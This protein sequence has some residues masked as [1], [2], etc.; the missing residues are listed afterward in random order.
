MKRTTCTHVRHIAT[1]A[2]AL[3]WSLS[4]AMC[5]ANTLHHYIF[6][7][8]DRERI[9]DSAFLNTK[10]I[11]GAQLKYT[12]RELEPSPDSYDFHAI[13]R[14]LNFLNSKKKRLFIQLQDVS[15]D[16]VYK[17]VPEY[18]L[19]VAEFHGGAD[20][21]YNILND[22]EAHATPAGWVAR[23]W[24]PA[25]RRRFQKLLTAL[26]K[27]F[28]GKIEGI[29]LPETAV[30]FGEK[31]GL[32]PKGFS[33]TLYRDAILSDMQALKHAFAKSV[34]MQYAN[35]MPGEWLP[36][37]DH[38]YLQSVYESARKL[39]VG[40]G[41]PDL[42]PFRRSQMSHSYPLIRASHNI[43]PTGIAVQDGN[44]GGISPKTRKPFPIPDLISFAR[45]YLRVDYLFWCTEEPY[46]SKN[47]IPFM[48]TGQ[49]L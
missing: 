31:G 36:D 17:C 25:V 39:K 29:N 34:T 4:W 40:V 3:G 38:H 46:Y 20:R 13:S 27:T 19:K 9:Y 14:D 37:Q 44:Y 5:R 24:D 45:N 30:D 1:F 49:L 8:F 6:F 21:Q 12:W 23:R 10:A 22:D 48:R 7:G 42:L 26:G 28:D 33:P 41:G 16:P 15:F 47:L 2:A 43:V 32:F 11:E 35:F 18:L